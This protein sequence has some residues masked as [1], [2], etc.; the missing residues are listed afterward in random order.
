MNKS[1]GLLTLLAL[2]C[3]ARVHAE[4]ALPVESS[5]LSVKLRL[6]LGGTVD[7]ISSASV[8][9]TGAASSDSSSRVSYG[10]AAQYTLRLQRYFGI[11]AELGYLSWRGA[12]SAIV[13][14]RNW[15][16]DLAVLPEGRLELADSVLLYLTV[17][18]GVSLDVLNEI[19]TLPTNSADDG[20]R[21]TALGFLV[22]GLVGVRLHI[23]N[24]FGVFAELGYVYRNFAHDL[25]VPGVTGFGAPIRERR[26]V[27]VAFGQLALNV[28]LCLFF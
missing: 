16:L 22:G 5:N 26:D 28:G 18:L 7:A 6:G 24:R 12:R 1:L 21:N 19:E 23:A 14:P 25:S 20:P 8:A 2:L 27:T 4:E 10:F 13:G 9:Q 11:G 3:S 17:P 15:L